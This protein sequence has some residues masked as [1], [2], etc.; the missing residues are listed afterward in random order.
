MEKFLLLL[1]RINNLLY[2]WT[3]H[4]V[5][6]TLWMSALLFLDSPFIRAWEAAGLIVWILLTVSSLFHNGL[7]P[8]PK[9]KRE[10][11]GYLVGFNIP[12]VLGPLSVGIVYLL[13]KY[14]EK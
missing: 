10:A 1:L 8:M 3:A 14:S 2:S 9:T 4:I 7:P 13:H 5:I 11:L 12:M 6:A